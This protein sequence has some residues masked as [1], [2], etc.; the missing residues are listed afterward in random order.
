MKQSANRLSEAM[1][2]KAFLVV[3]M[4]CVVATDAYSL[5]SDILFKRATLAQVAYELLVYVG[6]LG[7]GYCYGCRKGSN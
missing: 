1:R 7:I 3:L 5:V 2:G 4:V 6:L